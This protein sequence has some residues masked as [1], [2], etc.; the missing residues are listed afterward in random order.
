MR[1]RA[2]AQVVKWICAVYCLL[3]PLAYVDTLRYATPVA[4]FFVALVVFAVDQV[5]DPEFRA[6]FQ[7]TQN[8]V[9]G[10]G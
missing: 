6:E 1:T 4:S 3:S 8:G 10:V 7:P 2:R 9:F 5:W